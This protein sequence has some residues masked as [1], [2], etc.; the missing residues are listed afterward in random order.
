MKH[1]PDK[2][3]DPEE[4]KQLSQAYEILS[5]PEKRVIYDKY[6]VDGI[7]GVPNTGGFGAD[8]ADLFR[9]FGGQF[10]RGFS[11]PIGVTL[12]VQLQDLY[13]G[14]GITIE[15]NKVPIAIRIEPGMFSGLEIRS[16]RQIFD[17]GMQREVFF[18][19][20]EISH[21]NFTRSNADLLTELT[22]SI[23]EC[24]FGFQ[25]EITHLD[26]RKLS[27]ES[28]EGAGPINPGTVFRIDRKGM[29][30][31]Q[32]FGEFGNLYVR[33]KLELPKHLK[34]DN[35]QK[36]TLER[37]LEEASGQLAHDFSPSNQRDHEG[38]KS[39]VDADE[40][41]PSPPQASHRTRPLRPKRKTGTQAEQD[42]RAPNTDGPAGGREKFN[43]SSYILREAHI[44]DFGTTGMM[45]DDDEDGFAPFGFFFR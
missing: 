39:P 26:G 41:V 20:K 14:K 40:S 32:R 22:L 9:G 19:I 42:S 33:V 30:I 16:N 38:I 45:E 35:E 18:K 6:G 11:M 31:Y 1:H 13:T 34:L 5:D 8:M 25:K 7:N 15:L 4:F 44:S 2:G 3:G 27:I 17:R 36:S 37:L 28:P 12:G 21:P 29:P 10:S 43:R 24:L 23:R